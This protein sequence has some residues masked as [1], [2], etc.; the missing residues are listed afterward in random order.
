MCCIFVRL[1]VS[2]MLT[3]QVIS[4]K[5]GVRHHRL[6]RLLI[7][8]ADSLGFPKRIEYFIF[9][10]IQDAAAFK[11]NLKKLIPAI[12]STADIQKLRK[13]IGDHKKCGKHG[14]LKCVGINIAFSVKGLEKV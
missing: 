10:N 2:N 14:L 9:F 12:T 5:Y 13:D 11:R 7:A 8:S 6:L 3:A 4:C 1:V